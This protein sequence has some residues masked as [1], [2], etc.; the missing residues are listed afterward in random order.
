[1]CTD[2]G[3]EILLMTCRTYTED[4]KEGTVTLR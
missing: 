2:F 1:M 4:L 3:Y